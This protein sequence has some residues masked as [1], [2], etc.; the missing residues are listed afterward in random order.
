ME[1]WARRGEAE[2]RRNGEGGRLTL[3]RSL[4]PASIFTGRLP[5]L[6]AVFVYILFNS[7]FLVWAYQTLLIQI[8]SLYFTELLTTTCDF[9]F[10][11]KKLKS[12]YYIS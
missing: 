2:E 1:R 11:V 5:S 12:N 4:F 10:Y 7:S 3:F 9:C 6:L 8:S